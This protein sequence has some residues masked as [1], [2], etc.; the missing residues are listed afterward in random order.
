MIMKLRLTNHLCC[1]HNKNF[2]LYQVEY[3]HHDTIVGHVHSIGKLRKDQSIS[4]VGIYDMYHC[5]P[6]SALLLLVQHL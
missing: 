1:L 6:N 2:K 3:T 4:I 5:L